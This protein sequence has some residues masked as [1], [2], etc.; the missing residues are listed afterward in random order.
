[1]RAGM[2]ELPGIDCNRLRRFVMRE[3]LA[4]HATAFAMVLALGFAS[5]AWAQDPPAGGA[6]G[7][8]GRGGDPAATRLQSGG[9]DRRQPA[10]PGG[11][12]GGVIAGITREGEFML[13]YRTTA[14]A[15]AEGAFLTTVGSPE[16]P[17][18]DFRARPAPAGDTR[19]PSAGKHR[20][21]VYIAWLTPR[22]KVF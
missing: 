9:Q 4:L 16:T 6:A 8:S 12:I 10:P 7:K 2:G 14:G 5:V 11:R 20:H 13:D 15:G 21:N 22:T 19:N 1:P 18:A 3:R 17:G